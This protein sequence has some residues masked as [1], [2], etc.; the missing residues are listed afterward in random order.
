M[1]AVVLAGGL[2]ADLGPLTEGIPRACVPI[3]GVPNIVRSM[4]LLVSNGIQEFHVS[5]FHFPQEIRN[6]LS[7][8]SLAACTVLYHAE[9]I[10]LGTAG[11]VKNCLPFCDEDFLVIRGDC[12]FDFDLTDA[13]AFH[14]S[15]R[16]L[17]TVVSSRSDASPDSGTMLVDPEGRITRYSSPCVGALPCSDEVDTGIYLCSP[18]L[19]ELIPDGCC[20]FSK[21]VLPQ[22]LRHNVPLYCYASRGYWSDLGSV[23]SYLNCNRRFLESEG[24]CI[25]VPPDSETVV[26][27]P[28]YIGKNVSLQGC[29]VG[30][31]TVIGDNCILKGTR[32]EGCVLEEG[33][34][35][36][37]GSVARNAVLCHHSVLRE[38]SRIGDDCVIGADCEIGSGVTVPAGVNIYPS[39]RIPPNVFVSGTVHHELRTLIPNEGKILFPYGRD[40]GGAMIFEIGRALAELFDGDVVVGRAEQRDS[41]AAMTFCGGVIS[42]GKNVYDTGINDLQQFR[43]TVRNYAF[44]CGAFFQRNYSNL[45]LRLFDG[46]GMPLSVNQADRFIRVLSECGCCGEQ[47]GAYRVFRGGSKAYLSYLRSIGLPSRIS[48]RVTPSQILSRLL[49]RS[50][51]SSGYERLRVGDDWIR[52]ER[53]DGEPFDES[54]LTLAACVALGR[55]NSLVYVPLHLPEIAERVAA[56]YGFRIRRVGSEDPNARKLYPLTDPNAC[57]ILILRLLEE[58]RFGFGDFVASLPSF[59]VKHR[60]VS[61]PLSRGAVLRRLSVVGGAFGEGI[62]LHDGGGSVRVIPKESPNAFRVFGEAANSETAEELC[63]FYIKKLK[64]L[65]PD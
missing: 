48:L 25:S 50:S 57:A 9:S 20:D 46:N 7:D 38:D 26:E 40:F 3:S 35:C 62:L 58:E 34:T 41:S 2:G 13:I 31:Y 18:E 33:V 22:L 54:Y 8:P 43:F 23:S 21:D 4:R 49:P 14:R 24:N 65:K 44:R 63:E 59:C 15:H 10:P 6:A 36:S 16:G 39:N 42:C 19:L 5:L 28:C 51:D 27:A 30:P 55:R 1:K 32:L 47:E 61:S 17:L 37:V 29:H 64:G 45:V 53:P 52:A 11:S 56:S 12:A 60:D